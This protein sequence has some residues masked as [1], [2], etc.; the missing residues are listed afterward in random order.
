MDRCSFAYSS[1]LDIHFQAVVRTMN[2]IFILIGGRFYFDYILPTNWSSK[3]PVYRFLWLRWL[4]SIKMYDPKLR[5]KLSFFYGSIHVVGAIA[6]I[7]TGTFMSWSN[8]MV[9]VYPVIVQIWIAHRCYKI[10]CFTKNKK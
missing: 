2:T 1:V 6:N 10:I 5:L 4:W 8:I 9:N 7:T 3:N